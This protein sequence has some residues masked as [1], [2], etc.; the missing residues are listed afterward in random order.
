MNSSTFYLKKIHLGSLALYSFLLSLFLWI[1]ISFPFFFMS[2]LLL[3]TFY[4]AFWGQTPP[5]TVSVPGLFISI[6]PAIV[7]SL[8]V[9]ITNV[10]AGLIYNLLSLKLKG[11]RVE[12]VQEVEPRLRKEIKAENIEKKN[13]ENQQTEEPAD[14]PIE[15]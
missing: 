11:L 3:N 7:F 5:G 13:I 6:L 14:I 12:L 8:T 9:T 15:E 10:C 2:S 4:S 1:V